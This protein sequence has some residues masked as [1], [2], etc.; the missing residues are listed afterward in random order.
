MAAARTDPH[1][2]ALF[3][4][5]GENPNELS[6]K[7]GNTI[8]LIEKVD[9]DWLRGRIDLQEGIFPS[10]FVEIVIDIPKCK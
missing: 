2:V 9:S 7:A 10:S 4:F 6:F 1:G 5:D 8:S 3:D